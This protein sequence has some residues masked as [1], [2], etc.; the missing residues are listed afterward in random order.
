MCFTY[1]YWASS[2]YIPGKLFEVVYLI[3]FVM[4]LH[5]LLNI[6]LLLLVSARR[7]CRRTSRYPVKLGTLIQKLV[8][9]KVEISVEQESLRRTT[10]QQYGLVKA[11]ASR[12]NEE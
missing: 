7:T 10:W 3:L 9:T 4:C 8:A 11:W 1:E 5:F 2:M 12:K 6:E